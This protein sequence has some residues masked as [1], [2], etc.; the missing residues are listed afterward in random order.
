[1]TEAIIEVKC[2]KLTFK[3]WDGKIDFIFSKL[4]KN[5]S[6]GYSCFKV[7]VINNRIKEWLFKPPPR[8]GL[9]ACL[10]RSSNQECKSEE[11][12]AYIRLLEETPIV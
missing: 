4:M 12:E 1:M 2:G 8:D 7:D 6:F 10:I 11:V 9:E 5:P 3:L